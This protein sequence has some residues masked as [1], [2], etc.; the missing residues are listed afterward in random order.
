MG[1]RIVL[2]KG[3]TA[4]F[5]VIKEFGSLVFSSGCRF[6]HGRHA[7]VIVCQGEVNPTILTPGTPECGNASDEEFMR[8]GDGI[9]DVIVEDIASQVAKPRVIRAVVDEANA[10]NQS[11]AKRDSIYGW[12]ILLQARGPT[13]A[14]HTAGHD[15]A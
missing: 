2:G 3:A 10:T 9:P 8:S 13:V 7:R 11:N 14:F 4:E 1:M 12:P 6:E 15:N 5:L